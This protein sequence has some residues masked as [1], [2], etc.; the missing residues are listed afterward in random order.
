MGHPHLPEL[1]LLLGDHAH[2]YDRLEHVKRQRRLPTQAVPHARPGAVRHIRRHLEGMQRGLA[3]KRG[4][5][6]V[7]LERRVRDLE[8]PGA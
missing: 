3:D 7:S 1:F 8:K 6:A 5:S 4:A 2:V